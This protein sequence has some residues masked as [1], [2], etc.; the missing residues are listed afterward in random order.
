MKLGSAGEAFFVER[1][2]RHTL[3][4]ASGIATVTSRGF[5]KD[6]SLQ[7]PLVRNNSL[8]VA[9]TIDATDIL[10]TSETR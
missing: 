8:F 2:D 4:A 7:T 9:P 1:T 3:Q 5:E 6:K 10:G